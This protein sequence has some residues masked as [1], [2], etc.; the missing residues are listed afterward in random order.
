L[1]RQ[2]SDE[3]EKKGKWGKE[4]KKKEG[5]REKKAHRAKFKADKEKVEESKTKG[6]GVDGRIRFS[7]KGQPFFP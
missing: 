3:S 5:A 1:N 7:K 2:E 4:K 6:G